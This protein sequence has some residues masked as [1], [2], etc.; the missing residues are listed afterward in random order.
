MNHD[1]RTHV[2]IGNWQIAADF[3]LLG[4]AAANFI[5]YFGAVWL[6]IYWTH[7]TGWLLWTEKWI[8]GPLLLA[9]LLFALW[10]VTSQVE[11]E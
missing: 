9:Y 7:G 2:R 11:E 6:N 1:H 8:E 10:W 5:M 3:L 4:G